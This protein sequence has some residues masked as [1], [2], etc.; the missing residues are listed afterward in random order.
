M[1]SKNGGRGSKN[2]EKIVGV[3][4]E[5]EANYATELAAGGGDGGGGDGGGGDGGG[6]DG[7]GDGG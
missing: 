5:E 1:S 6:G 7:G 3:M 4:V 2:D